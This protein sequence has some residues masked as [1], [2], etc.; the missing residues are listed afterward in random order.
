MKKIA[1]LE[2]ELAVIVDNKAHGGGEDGREGVRVL[3]RR[4]KAKA[5][6]GGDGGGAGTKER[7]N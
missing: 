2:A 1:S 7:S 5:A 6:E 3:R 4:L